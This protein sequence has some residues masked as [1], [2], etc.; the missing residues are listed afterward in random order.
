MERNAGLDTEHQKLPQRARHPIQALLSLTRFL[1]VKGTLLIGGIVGVGYFVLPT[2]IKQQLLQAVGG[3][4]QGTGQGASVGKACEAS[5][6]NAKACDFSR[7]VLAST[8]DVWTTQF[9]KAELPTYGA[10]PPRT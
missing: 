4:A 5:P 9:Q 7:A 10:A 1:G 2:S 3:S 6:A 8:E